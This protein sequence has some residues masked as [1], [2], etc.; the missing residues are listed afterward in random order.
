MNEE[1]FMS[2]KFYEGRGGGT[3]IL[4]GHFAIT[5]TSDASAGETFDLMFNS[6]I[7]KYRVSRSTVCVE[8]FNKV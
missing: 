8:Q 6:V 4:V 1:Y 5:A 3:K 2:G 7:D